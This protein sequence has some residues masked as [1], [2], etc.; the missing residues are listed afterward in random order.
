MSLQPGP[1]E[2]LLVAVLEAQ[3]KGEQLCQMQRRAMRWHAQ[4]LAQ[5][6]DWRLHLVAYRHQVQ[7]Q[8]LAGSMLALLPA[9]N[10]RRA[11]D[12]AL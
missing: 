5:G 10:D 6:M 9:S 3:D 4:G 11:T 8:R 12:V 2:H 1:I 7:L